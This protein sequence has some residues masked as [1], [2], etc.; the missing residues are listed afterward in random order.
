MKKI[1]DDADYDSSKSE[2]EERRSKMKKGVNSLTSM[3]KKCLLPE[4]EDIG[5]YR[6]SAVGQM[7]QLLLALAKE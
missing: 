5:H 4:Q 6:S 1:V 2:V 3:M 7:G